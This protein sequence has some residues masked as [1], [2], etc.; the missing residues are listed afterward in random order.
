VKCFFVTSM[1]LSLGPIHA[2]AQS[3]TKAP[4]EA[5]IVGTVLGQQ[6]QPLKNISVHAVLEQTGMHAPTANS[7][8]DGQFV[9]GDLEPGTYDIFG[10]SMLLVI[11]TPSC[12]STLTRIQSR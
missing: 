2:H 1:L 12:L 7:N 8:G 11:Q 9:I 4:A 3:D 6:A 10:E 5:R